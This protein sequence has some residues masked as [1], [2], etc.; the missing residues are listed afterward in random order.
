MAQT[1]I[2]VTGSD[3]AVDQAVAESQSNIAYDQIPVTVE[4]KKD[5][6]FYTTSQYDRRK[7]PAKRRVRYL[8]E[9]EVLDPALDYHHDFL[10]IN[11]CGK[12]MDCRRNGA[13]RRWKTDPRRISLPLKVGFRECFRVDLAEA[14][15]TLVT[16]TPDA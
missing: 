3:A 15:A 2:I 7:S 12:V 13:T 9:D 14:I 4:I 8:T 10:M 16:E 6:W 5:P 11:R 1:T